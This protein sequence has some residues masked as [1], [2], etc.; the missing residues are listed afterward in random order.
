[1]VKR[2]QNVEGIKYELVARVQ[3]IVIEISKEET[4]VQN[5]QCGMGIN[6]QIVHP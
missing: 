6:F 2:L 5:E 4:E 3:H 1:M